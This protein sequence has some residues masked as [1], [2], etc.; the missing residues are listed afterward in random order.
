MITELHAGPQRCGWFVV[1]VAGV[2]EWQRQRFPQG[3]A[4]VDGLPSGTE[5]GN[6]RCM[7]V[8]AKSY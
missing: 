1:L 2:P 4:L 5:V 7:Q 3:L 6:L 8:P